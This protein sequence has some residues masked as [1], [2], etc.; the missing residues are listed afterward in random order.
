MRLGADTW[1]TRWSG[2]AYCPGAAEPRGYDH[3]FVFSTDA[4][5]DEPKAVY[6]DPVSGRRM[7][8]FT[9]EPATQLYTGNFL[10]GHSCGKNGVAFFPHGGLCL[11]AQHFPDSPNRP[12]YPTTVLRPGERYTQITSYVFATD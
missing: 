4:A 8:M 7:E 2:C 12:E 10:K 3:N 9:T 6:R 5:A 1:S 11:E